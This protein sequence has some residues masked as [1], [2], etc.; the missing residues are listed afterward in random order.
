MQASHTSRS[1][2]A[3]KVWSKSGR[4]LHRRCARKSKFAQRNPSRSILSTGRRRDDQGPSPSAVEN[5]SCRAHHGKISCSPHPHTHTAR[6][7]T[8]PPTNLPHAV[9]SLP[10]AVQSSNDVFSVCDVFIHP[11]C[12]LREEALSLELFYPLVGPA[13]RLLRLVVLVEHQSAET[14]VGQQRLAVVMVIAV[15]AG[16]PE[17][18]TTSLEELVVELTGSVA[19]VVSV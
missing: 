1:Q 9:T 8:C 15:S 18:L 10:S 4:S 6:T 14:A 12:H 7:P 3:T 5:R 16:K 13:L 11:L 2:P 19:E 17:H